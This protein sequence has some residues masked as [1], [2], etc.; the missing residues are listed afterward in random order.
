MQLSSQQIDIFNK[1]QIEC[2]IPDTLKIPLHS[3]IQWGTA[4]CM[5]DRA[6]RL[7]EVHLPTPSNGPLTMADTSIWQPIELFVVTTDQRY[8]PIT[9]IC[10]NGCIKKQIPWSAFAMMDGDWKCIQEAADILAVSL[11][12]NKPGLWMLIFVRQ[13][14]QLDLAVLFCW[15]KTYTLESSSGHWRTSNFMGEETWQPSLCPV[16]RCAQQWTCKDQQI[17]FRVWWKTLIYHHTW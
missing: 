14:F 13:G 8:G 7:H 16:L 5:L 2:N 9:T 4:F 6:Y 11:S 1:F 10:C 12:F 15:E 3:N 17:L